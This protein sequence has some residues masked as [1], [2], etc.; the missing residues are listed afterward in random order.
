MAEKMR[1]LTNDDLKA[2]RE[3]LRQLREELATRT[4]DRLHGHGLERHDDAGLPRRAEDTDDDGTA[5]QQRSADLN[6]LSGLADRLAAVDDALARLE[7]GEYG[8][9]VECGEPID[10]A[11]LRAAPTALRCTACQ[12]KLEGRVIRTRT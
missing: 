7:R 5:E 8:E 2:F 9:C 11:R 12:A 1:A 6:Q 4:E 3:Q 10:T